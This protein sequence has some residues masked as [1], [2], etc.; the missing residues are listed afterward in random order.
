[1]IN[2]RI[3]P[4]DTHFLWLTECLLALFS[5]YFLL[6]SCYLSKSPCDSPF[7]RILPQTLAAARFVSEPR[8]SS[9]Q[10]RAAILIRVP[11]PLRPPTTTKHSTKKWELFG[12][13]KVSN[14]FLKV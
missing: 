14:S 5:Y 3:P 13:K 12:G 4:E 9:S 2:Q 10:Q 1:M 11:A 7:H 6:P 8:L